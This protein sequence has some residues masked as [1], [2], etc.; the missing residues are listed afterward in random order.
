MRRGPEQRAKGKRTGG[1]SRTWTG[2]LADE[3][4]DSAVRMAARGQRTTGQPQRQPADGNPRTAVCSCGFQNPFR[5]EDVGAIADL[6]PV[7]YASLIPSS[8]RRRF[9][10]HATT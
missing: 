7:F 8:F 6:V 1:E 2:G 10:T 4:Q 5:R 3:V 9:V